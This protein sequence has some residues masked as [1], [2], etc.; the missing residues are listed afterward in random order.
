VENG[1]VD[2]EVQTLGVNKLYNFSLSLPGQ[3]ISDIN[4]E[5]SQLSLPSEICSVT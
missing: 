5:L 2:L 1:R 3:Q 4:Y